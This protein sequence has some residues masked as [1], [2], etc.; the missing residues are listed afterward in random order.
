MHVGIAATLDPLQSLRGGAGD[1]MDSAVVNIWSTYCC[2]ML[3]WEH[4]M[5]YLIS[6]NLHKIP[7]KY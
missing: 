4:S 5:G 3:R 2:Q 7:M 6:F 1:F